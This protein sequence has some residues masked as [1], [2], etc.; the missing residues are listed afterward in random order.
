MKKLFGEF[1]PWL[2]FL[3]MVTNVILSTISGNE[4]QEQSQKWFSEYSQ[5]MDDFTTYVRDGTKPLYAR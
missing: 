4:A 5:C 2:L 3:I 1:L